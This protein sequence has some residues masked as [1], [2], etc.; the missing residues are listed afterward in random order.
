[1]HMLKT[2]ALR[3]L[4]LLSLLSGAGQ[5][6][7]APGYHVTVDTRP[8]AGQAGYIDFLMLSLANATP[9]EAA[10][11]HF[12]GDFGDASYLSGDAAGTLADGIAIGNGNGFGNFGQWASFGGI[13]EFDVSFTTGSGEGP[14][15]NLGIALLDADWNY[16]GAPGDIVTFMLQPGTVDTVQ[17]DPSMAAVSVPEPSTL[18]LLMPCLMLVWLSRRNKRSL[19]T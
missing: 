6:L 15:T 18:A 17:A 3:F 11:S 1:M 13:F 2:G 14:G 12:R 9:V 19:D 7:G 4:F 10:I 16:L 8:L 5:A